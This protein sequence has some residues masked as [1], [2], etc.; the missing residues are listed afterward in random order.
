ME[1]KFTFK[2][3]GSSSSSTS[4]GTS[5]NQNVN[6]A[7]GCEPVKPVLPV[8]SIP[9][10]LKNLGPTTTSTTTPTPSSI[11]SYTSTA[12]PSKN[13]HRDEEQQESGGK[14]INKP[15]QKSNNNDESPSSKPS[16]FS[17]KK[18][19]NNKVTKS[20]VAQATISGF[21]SKNAN[22]A[23]SFKKPNL[24]SNSSSSSNNTYNSS[25]GCGDVSTLMNQFI[26]DETD[27]DWSVVEKRVKSPKPPVNNNNNNM[28][29]RK[30]EDESKVAK[31]KLSYKSPTKPGRE[32]QCAPSMMNINNSNIHDSK[33]TISN[34]ISKM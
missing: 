7:S 14:F 21:L 2:L 30:N 33:P 28:T 11:L 22:A 13:G 32:N 29:S 25:S 12:K 26:Q 31:A 27:D 4:V 23:G 3:P 9:F 19:T 10:S 34:K 6:R 17:Q 8:R 16:L 24:S 20:I 1:R 15:F 18:E 5:N